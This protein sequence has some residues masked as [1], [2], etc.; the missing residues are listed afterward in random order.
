MEQVFGVGLETEFVGQL[1]C[2][3]KEGGVGVNVSDLWK[4][5]GVMVS[6]LKYKVGQRSLFEWDEVAGGERAQ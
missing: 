3:E 5:H 1:T 4:L 6:I 2:D